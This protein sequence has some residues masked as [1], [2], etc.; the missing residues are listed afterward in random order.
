MNTF[1]AAWLKLAERG[2]CDAYMGAE[3]QRVWTEYQRSGEG[4]P[5]DWFIIIHANAPAPSCSTSP[6][7]KAGAK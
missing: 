2:A 3:Y 4:C 1:D 7:G 5:P 6:T